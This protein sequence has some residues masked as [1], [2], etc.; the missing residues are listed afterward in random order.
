VRLDYG[1]LHTLDGGLIR[2]IEAHA[3]SEAARQAAGLSA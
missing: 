3:T 1:L 2:R